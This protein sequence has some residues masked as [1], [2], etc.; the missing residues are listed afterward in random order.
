MERY[1]RYQSSRSRPLP[2]PPASPRSLYPKNV[3]PEQ[4]DTAERTSR[5]DHPPDTESLPVIQPGRYPK[6][7]K[8]N[9]PVVEASI[10]AGLVAV[11][12]IVIVLFLQIVLDSR[13]TSSPPHPEPSSP[14]PQDYPVKPLVAPGGGGFV[15]PPAWK[16]RPE[17]VPEPSVP[18]NLAEL[19]KS[20]DAYVAAAIADCRKGYFGPADKVGVEISRLWPD[21]DRGLA[22]RLLAGYLAQ[23]RSLA[24]EAFDAMGP[25]T[26]I[27][28]GRY[29]GRRYGIGAFVERRG[30][31]VK[32]QA[33]GKYLELTRDEF[34]VIDGLRFRRTKQY[35]EAGGK[36]ANDLIL[37]AFHF[38]KKVDKNGQFQADATISR[39]LAEARW[40][41]AQ[42]CKDDLVSEHGT[43][44]LTLLGSSL[45]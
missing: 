24:D 38:V 44:L 16:P 15:K 19:P 10:I 25:G 26:E 11:F 21:D 20:I 8:S 9:L 33:G 29:G 36:P 6:K 45:D 32:F 18:A 31:V 17:R 1:G 13:N 3:V 23:Y 35:L 12:G 37:G 41:K 40:R 34:N 30:D 2:P 22:V 42:G 14:K 4:V 27:Y 39:G 7:K 5:D 28:L 43:A